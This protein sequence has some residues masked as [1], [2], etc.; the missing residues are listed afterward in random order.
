[1][2]SDIENPEARDRE[3]KAAGLVKGL[4]ACNRRACQRNL[5][6]GGVRW[7]NIVTRAWHCQPCAFRIN[8]ADQVLCVPENEIA[9]LAKEDRP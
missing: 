7:W 8:E 5:T 3:T 2:R 1:M 4:T 6:R 9:D